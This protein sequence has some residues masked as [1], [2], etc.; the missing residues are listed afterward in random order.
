[1][2]RASRAP[3]TFIVQIMFGSPSLS[4]TFSWASPC[5]ED[6]NSLANSLSSLPSGTSSSGTDGGPSS[7]EQELLGRPF[8]LTLARWVPSSCSSTDLETSSLR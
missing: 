8:E 6:G 7:Y 2:C 3:F 4:L 5:E 1:M